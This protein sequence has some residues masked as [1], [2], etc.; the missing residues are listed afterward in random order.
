MERQETEKGPAAVRKPY[1]RP[2]LIKRDKLARVTGDDEII[3]GGT[4]A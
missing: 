2:R 4:V 1:L 3:S